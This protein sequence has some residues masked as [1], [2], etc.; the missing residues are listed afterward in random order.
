MKITTTRELGAYGERLANRYLTESGLVVVDRNWRCV[1]GEIDIVAVENLALVV[2]EVKTR[3]SE[4]FG[5][6]FEAVGRQ[7][8]R[9]L[10]LLAGLWVEQ[11]ASQVSWPGPRRSIGDLRIDVVSIL[12]G[13]AGPITVAHLRGVE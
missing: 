7:K 6:P 11:R 2:C 4:S 12:R 3:S 5:M 8:L 10:R 1:R 13:S 9:R